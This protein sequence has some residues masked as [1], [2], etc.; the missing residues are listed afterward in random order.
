MNNK[1]VYVVLMHRYG[2]V[3]GH[4]YIDG[5]YSDRKIARYEAQSHILFRGNK[6]YAAIHEHWVDGTSSRTLVETVDE[7]MDEEEIDIAIKSRKEWL[8]YREKRLKELNEK[9]S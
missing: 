8:K 9:N 6:Y 3:E 4:T 1:F 7:A 5:V 2:D